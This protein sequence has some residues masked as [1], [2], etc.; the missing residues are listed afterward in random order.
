MSMCM[1]D[2]EK[3]SVVVPCYNE[4][5]GISELMSR[6]GPVLQEMELRHE[7]ILVDDGSEDKT[8]KMIGEFAGKGAVRG[9]RLSRNY[10]HQLAISA[11]LVKSSGDI[12]F[13]IDADL[14]DP[15]E[16]F[17]EMLKLIEQ[18][19]DVVYGQRIRRKGVSWWKKV[20]YKNY[21]RILRFLAGCPI[22]ADTGDFRAMRR[23]VVDAIVGMPEQQRFLRGMIS[24]L[25]FRQVAYPYE[26]DPRFAGEAKY[27]LRKLFKLAWDGIMSFSIQPLRLALICGAGLSAL[28]FG[29]IVYIVINKLVFG[30]PPEGWSSLMAVILLIGGMQFLVLGIMGEYLGRVFLESKRRPLY[31]I[32]E[33]CG[34]AP[35]SGEAMKRSEEPKGN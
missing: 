30:H 18:G 28:S 20:C 11:G 9:I 5:D 22:P 7:I 1:K 19:N 14:Q 6:L 12:V 31:L 16:L 10:G 24:W 29:L 33:E 17:P 15:P 4:E 21:Y 32:Q 34:C 23:H 26:R 27:T 35:E 8:W 3:L 2:I 25:G 13:V